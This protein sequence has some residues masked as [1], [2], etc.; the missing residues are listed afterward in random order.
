MDIARSLKPT[1]SVSEVGQDPDATQGYPH[2][3]S[4]QDALV[5]G[6]LESLLEGLIQESFH[7]WKEEEEEEAQE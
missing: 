4:P 7:P 3:S 1:A 5:P 6:T 2:S